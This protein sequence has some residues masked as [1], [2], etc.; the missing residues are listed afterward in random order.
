MKTIYNFTWISFS[1]FSVYPVFDA[2]VT[3]LNPPNLI[4]SSI[5]FTSVSGSGPEQPW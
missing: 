5:A 3:P 2:P 4:K 1:L